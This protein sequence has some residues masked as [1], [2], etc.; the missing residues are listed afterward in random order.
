MY[1]LT[2]EE[3]VELDKF[4]KDNLE[5]G[6]VRGHLFS[7]QPIPNSVSRTPLYIPPHRR[8]HRHSGLT[9]DLSNI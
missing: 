1:N 2:P 9:P 7:S 5:K 4:L 3:Q 8:E 6:Y